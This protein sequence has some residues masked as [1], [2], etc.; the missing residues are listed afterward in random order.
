MTVS[1]LEFVKLLCVMLQHWRCSQLMD[2]EIHSRILVGLFTKLSQHSTPSIHETCQV[3]TFKFNVSKSGDRD[4]IGLVNPHGHAM[5][6][7][8]QHLHTPC[9]NPKLTFLI[10]RSFADY[11]SNVIVVIFLEHAS[12]LQ[13]VDGPS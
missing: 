1:L 13:R 6:R 7:R 12:K 5:A 2:D 11:S 4:G 9:S 8:V 10:N 3:M